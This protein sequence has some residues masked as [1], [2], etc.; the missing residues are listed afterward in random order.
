MEQ[1][2]P[3][4]KGA[5][6]GAAVSERHYGFRITGEQQQLQ[7]TATAFARLELNDDVILRDRDEIFSHQG[8]T[9]C[10]GFGVQGLP[11][12]PEHD[13]RASASLRRSP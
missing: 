5:S 8:W 2:S 11:V 6:G 9:A 3:A 1:R 12:P 7:N 13:G 10:A 4:R